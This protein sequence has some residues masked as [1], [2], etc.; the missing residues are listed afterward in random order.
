MPKKLTSLAPVDAAPPARPVLSCDSREPKVVTDFLRQV[1]PIKVEQRVI[2]DYAFEDCDGYLNLITRKAADFGESLFS[3]HFGE[4]VQGC[5]TLLKSLGMGRLWWLQEGPWF[6]S[7]RPQVDL[8]EFG[9][10][11]A[12]HADGFTQDKSHDAAY[13]LIPATQISMQCAGVYYLTTTNMMETARTIGILYDR[14]QRGW[15]SG[16]PMRLQRPTL[17]WHRDDEFR[18]IARLM[19]LWPRLSE[20]QA[21]GLLAQYHSIAAIIQAVKDDSLTFPGIGDKMRKS[22]REVTL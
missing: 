1:V 20:R 21:A 3:G 13:S 17:R 22:F 16:L 5:M 11:H 12:I 4:E 7:R 9:I 19:S 6:S 2:G 8:S 14:G 18:R 10:C 15:P